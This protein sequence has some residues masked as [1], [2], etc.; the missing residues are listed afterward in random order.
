MGNFGPAVGVPVVLG[1]H[2][3]LPILLGSYFPTVELL[4]SGRDQGN[5]AIRLADSR[6]KIYHRLPI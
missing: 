1:Q 3:G 4:G 2:D 5:Q 6:G